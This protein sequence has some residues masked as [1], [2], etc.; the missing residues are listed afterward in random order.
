MSLRTSR[1]SAALHSYRVAREREAA[2]FRAKRNV[3]WFRIAW[4]AALFGLVV[5]VM[6]QGRAG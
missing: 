2:F 3:R 5:V 6:T 4:A 1:A